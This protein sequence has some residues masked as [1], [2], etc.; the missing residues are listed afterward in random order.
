MILLLVRELPSRAVRDY[1]SSHFSR[2]A[3][4]FTQR[5]GC[6]RVSPVSLLLFL[7]SCYIVCSRLGPVVSRAGHLAIEAFEVERRILEEFDQEGLKLFREVFGKFRT[8][9]RAPYPI[10]LFGR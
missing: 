8:V 9:T 7:L 4:E 3:S 10:V 1:L 5:G 6:L 2:N